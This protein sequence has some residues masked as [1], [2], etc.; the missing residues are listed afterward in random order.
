MSEITPP[1]GW[2]PV[3]PKTLAVGTRLALFAPR[4]KWTPALVGNFINALEKAGYVIVEKPLPT[5][6]NPNG[7]RE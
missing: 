1:D 7:E 3:S 4:V 2:T 6:L 5:P